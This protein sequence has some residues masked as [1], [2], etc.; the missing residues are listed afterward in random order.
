MIRERR[1]PRAFGILAAL[2][3]VLIVSLAGC[4]KGTLGLKGGGISGSVLD[5]RTLTGVSGV[6][7]WAFS[8]GDEEENN[9]ATKF[10][11]TDSNGNYYFS[12]MR[13]GGSTAAP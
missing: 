6:S 11:T 9:S 13:S 8:V 3:L 4:E 10:T 1:N 2:F 5:S 12:S 7:V